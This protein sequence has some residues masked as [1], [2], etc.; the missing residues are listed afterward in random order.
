MKL[1][2]IE[3]LFRKKEKKEYFLAL[4][5]RDEKVTAVIFEELTGK[6][7]VVGKHEELLKTPLE[8]AT[9]D[10]WLDV[11][12][13]T[14]SQAES[15]LPQNVETQK[16]IF[17]VKDAWV[18][19]SKIKKEYL[20]R[21]KKVSDTLG[22]LPIGFLVIH[23]AIAHLLQEE[24]GAPVSGI[25][26]EIGQKNIT[27]SLLRA[28]RI[29]ETKQTTIGDNVAQVIDNL[30]HHFTSYEVLPSRMLI[31][32]DTENKEKL[33]QIFISHTWS[34]SLPFLHVPQISILPKNFDAKAVLSGAASQMGFEFITTE[35][36]KHNIEQQ[37]QQQE[38]E[39]E[40]FGFVKGIDVRKKTEEDHKEINIIQHNTPKETNSQEEVLPTEEQTE[41]PEV[42]HATT[43]YSF[44]KHYLAGF[45][46]F[47]S[48]I[49]GIVK[50]FPLLLPKKLFSGDLGRK[51]VF[52][53][54]FFA[55]I[56]V[57]GVIL[58]LVML[59]ATVTLSIT[60]KIIEQKQHISFTTKDQ[61]DTQKN[62]IAA[63]N[64][65]VEE[66]GKATKAATGKKEV[67]TPAKGT[68]TIYN[69]TSQSKTLS[70]GTILTTTNDL[71]FALDTSVTIASAS[72]A[73]DAFSAIT[74]ST[75]K[76]NVTA[77]NIGKESNLPSGTVFSIKSF[78]TND[79]A[80]KNDTAFS[81]GTKKEVTV[82]SKNDIAAAITDITNTLEEKAKQDM[83]QKIDGQN[84]LLPI[85]TDASFIQEDLDKKLN[86]EASTFTLSGTVT[87]ES[88]SYKE[89][90]MQL[91]IKNLLSQNT[92]PTLTQANTTYDLQDAKQEKNTITA[93]V[94]AKSFLLPKLDNEKIIQSI[95]SKSFTEAK[96]I[97]LRIPQVSDANITL[98]PNIP[99]LPSL[100]PRMSRNITL[101]TKQQ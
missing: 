44:N 87:F 1:P 9:L 95:T 56:V 100:L 76:A 66:K 72:G 17:G 63:E 27:V 78:G 21:L 20:I 26:V 92:D 11:F 80:A 37:Q 46:S 69:K 89:T 74:P 52:F 90:D 81:G 51:K 3:S 33:S 38:E 67:G 31:V 2:F 59:K 65:T 15:T 39:E 88:L 5:L 94:N 30:L 19:D 61:T 54:T 101:D 82:V 53:P 50:K 18:E 13:K 8:D 77:E 45:L 43:P 7:R 98:V 64:V 84:K 55:I 16:T 75:A 47:L 22:L 41:E 96:A 49:K 4:L 48:I 40:A 42:K 36:K 57:I 14:I 68:V 73:A 91:L 60:P 10:D 70:S 34:K 25:L 35:T 85:I 71:T 79:I 62:I 32:N 6:V 29:I 83:I 99:L 28:G 97:L 24:E 23:E 12:D 93:S 58:Y 86:E